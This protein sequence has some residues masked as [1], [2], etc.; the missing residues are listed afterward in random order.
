ME[1]RAIAAA[2][3]NEFLIFHLDDKMTKTCK[4]CGI[5]FSHQFTLEAHM[6][7][8]C[9]RRQNTM[10]EINN[11]PKFQKTWR[12]RQ[13]N[14]QSTYSKIN[15]NNNN[16]NNNNDGSTFKFFCN[17]ASKLKNVDLNVSSKI[18]MNSA[19]TNNSDTNQLENHMN[20][21]SNPLIINSTGNKKSILQPT[22]LSNGNSCS[23]NNPNTKSNESDKNR[24]HNSNN[25]DSEPEN[26]GAPVNLFFCAP[27]G[28][29]FSSK[30]LYNIHLQ[31]DS[32][33]LQLSAS[34]CNSLVLAAP[35][36]NNN[37]IQYVPIHP[38]TAVLNPLNSNSGK[39][40]QHYKPNNNNNNN[41][42]DPST[43]IPLDLSMNNNSSSKSPI[44]LSNDRVQIDVANRIAA[45]AVTLGLP[46]C[47]QMMRSNKR[48]YLCPHC[49]TR[50]QLYSTFQAHQEFY[51]QGKRQQT[52][53][54]TSEKR[55][56]TASNN[57][58]QMEFDINIQ[59]N[60]D[61]NWNLCNQGFKC[62]FCGFI[63]QT[64]RGIRIHCKNQCF[65]NKP[66]NHK[67]DNKSEDIEVCSPTDDHNNIL[68]NARSPENID[69]YQ[70][71]SSVKIEPV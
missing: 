16:N 37:G 24:N 30:D 45:V 36:I 8:Y 57:S 18:M 1:S 13:R 17:D 20:L 3:E 69:F 21:N 67:S 46:N 38:R 35:L 2:T 4:Y 50:F 64:K 70:E 40:Q 71:D 32:T 44:T 14:K 5:N 31:L 59:K 52:D 27:C 54:T 61:G 11:G 43:A 60:D 6:T 9:S 26:N 47:N 12:T 55:S 58:G 41:F 10:T 49:Q 29:F 39:P 66:K 34:K 68:V 19:F 48:P 56:R 25:S 62:N 33:S 51:C 28:L 7:Y 63:G 53:I 15:T 42:E 65:K 22:I 23:S